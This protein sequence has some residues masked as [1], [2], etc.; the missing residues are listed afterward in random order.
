MTIEE[1]EQKLNALEN[2]YRTL[3]N[4]YREHAHT[5]IDGK[6]VTATALAGT[7]L[8]SVSSPSGGPTIDSQARSAI[9]T[10]ITRLETLG[11]I[12]SN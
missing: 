4:E 3:A 6:G 9:D 2:E 11:L 1:L 12:Q 5:G 7:P 10:I 8:A